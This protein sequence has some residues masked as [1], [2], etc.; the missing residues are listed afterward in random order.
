MTSDPLLTTP[1]SAA[2]RLVHLTWRRPSAHLYQPQKPHRVRPVSQPAS[3]SIRSINW[4]AAP[5]PITLSPAL[6]T[7]NAH[8]VGAQCLYARA[9]QAEPKSGSRRLLPDQIS[10]FHRRPPRETPPR[11]Q[12]PR[13]GRRRRVRADVTKHPRCQGPP[14]RANITRVCAGPGPGP[15]P[16]PWTREPVDLWYL[17]LVWPH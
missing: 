8:P 11:T 14:P 3:Q 2:S 4:P 13:H 1:M 16:G 15:G 10:N 17:V 9:A 7:A 12:N 6:I 5:H